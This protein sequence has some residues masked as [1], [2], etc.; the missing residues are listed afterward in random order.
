MLAD[1]GFEC[2]LAG[3]EDE[4]PNLVARLRGEAEGP[5]LCLLGHADTVPADASEW[6]PRP[7]ER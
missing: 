2:E 7:V 5:T 4:R 6:S 1:A 3:A